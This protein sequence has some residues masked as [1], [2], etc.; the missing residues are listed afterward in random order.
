M[1]KREVRRVQTKISSTSSGSWCSDDGNLRGRFLKLAF[2]ATHLYLG[3]LLDSRLSFTTHACYLQERTAA[4][5]NILWMFSRRSSGASYRVLPVIYFH[6]VCSAIDCNAP[7]L[8]SLAP[9]LLAKLE[10]AQK[11]AV[12]IIMGAPILCRKAN[13]QTDRDVFSLH[14]RIWPRQRERQQS[15][16]ILTYC[17]DLAIS[18]GPDLRNGIIRVRNHTVLYRLWPEH[19]S[20][21]QDSD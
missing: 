18:L 19:A 20:M 8:Y 12:H 10:V 15:S 4:R 1:P 3:I 13:L 7:C 21:A 5:S 11:D 9:L 2:A 6:A 17:R 14:Q 16:V